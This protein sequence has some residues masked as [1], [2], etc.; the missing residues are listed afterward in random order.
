MKKTKKDKH[1]GVSRQPDRFELIYEHTPVA[2]WEED[3][4]AVA[5]L[6][7]RL[8]REGVRNIS[9]YVLRHP[10]IIKQTFRKIKIISVN[11]AA[12]SLYGATSKKQLI[13]NFGKT[14]TKDARRVVVDEFLA[15]AQGKRFFE[16]EF[17]SK[18]LK[19]SL[20]DVLLRVSVPD[21][22]AESLARVIV[23]I[24][25]ITAQKRLERH[26]K[27][28]AQLDGL[29][30]LYNSRT[31]SQRLNEELTRARRYK[32][33]LSC[34]MLDIDYFKVVNDR[35]GHQRGD[36]VLK[37]V[38]KVLRDSMRSTDI[39]SR[40]GGDEFFIILV[41]TKTDNAKLAAERI[42]K[43][44]ASKKLHLS[45]KGSLKVTMSIG[46]SGYPADKIKDYRDLIDEADRALYLAKSY[47]RNCTVTA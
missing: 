47:G 13:A 8:R 25:D 17:K 35:F 29:T 4:S 39:I 6:F 26:L 37:R 19:G 12:L 11:K 46:V 3:L 5:Q 10:N 34:L 21:Q 1:I 45:G 32:L 14:I 38:A 16:A 28:T 2:I 9:S 24:Q 23:T 30:K 44:I 42:R 27:R 41:Q 43:L 40:Y 20:P 7:A 33:D 22:Y 36:Q 15:L 18:T 31:L